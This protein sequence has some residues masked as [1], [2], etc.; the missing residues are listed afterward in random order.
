MGSSQ[1]P[2]EP[3]KVSQI[4]KNVVSKNIDTNILIHKDY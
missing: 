1:S 4:P 3:L 2:D